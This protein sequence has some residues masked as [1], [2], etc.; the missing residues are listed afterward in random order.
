MFTGKSVSNITK[1]TQAEIFSD[2]EQTVVGTVSIPANLAVG[3]AL[4]MGTL[5]TSSDG[6]KTWKSLETQAYDVADAPFAADAE[7][8][9]QGSTFKSLGASNSAA[10]TDTDSW[11]NLGEW[12][13]NGVLY[14]DIFESKKTT[15]VVTGDVISK[16]IIGLD[17]FLNVILFKNKIITK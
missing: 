15:V 14:N 9:Y 3:E 12:N 6:G 8:Y 2:V 5:L 13:A 10:L 4:R 17:D 1:R 7:V 11:E 16:H